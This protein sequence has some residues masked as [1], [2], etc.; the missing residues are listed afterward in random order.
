MSIN[1]DQVARHEP[2]QTLCFEILYNGM[3]KKI[4]I[5]RDATVKMLLDRAIAIFGNLPQPHT[6]ALWT[7]K[8]VELT[9]EQETLKAAHIKDSESLILRPSAVKGG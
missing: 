2:K 6:L 8:G 9:N 1:A 3:A 7:E 5:D 4:E